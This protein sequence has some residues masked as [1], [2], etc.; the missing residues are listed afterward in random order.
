M[1]STVRAGKLYQHRDLLV[2]NKFYSAW[3]GVCCEKAFFPNF[4]VMSNNLSHNTVVPIAHGR[5]EYALGFVESSIDN[6]LFNRNI[7]EKLSCILQDPCCQLITRIEAS[8]DGVCSITDGIR[9]ERVTILVTASQ[10]VFDEH[11]ELME[12][13]KLT[14]KVDEITGLQRKERFIKTHGHRYARY[15]FPNFYS[16]SERA[17]MI[18]TR[19]QNL[20]ACDPQYASFIK[21]IAA[22][23][24]SIHATSLDHE[25]LIDALLRIGLL[26]CAVP[27]HENH[28]TKKIFSHTLH[29]LPIR[30]D[31]SLLESYF[32]SQVTF[33]FA[34]MD[35]FTLWL[36]V[37]AIVGA[38]VWGLRESNQTVDTDTSSTFYSLFMVIWGFFFIAFWRRRANELACDWDTLDVEHSDEPNPRYHG[39]TRISRITG[40]NELFYNPLNRWVFHYPISVV[41]T[42]IM[43]I[44]AFS[45]MALSLNLQG[46]VSE[47]SI[48]Y[49]ATLSSCS[50][51]GGIFDA[52][53]PVLSL[54]PVVLHAGVI[55]L[56]NLQYRHVA[57]W[58]TEQ[59]NH[60]LLHQRESSL[61]YKRFLFE[62]FDCYIALF[63]VAFYELDILKLRGELMSLYCVDS[64]RRVAT[65]SLLPYVLHHLQLWQQHWQ[66]AHS[67]KNDGDGQGGTYNALTGVRMCYIFCRVLHFVY[68]FKYTLFSLKICLCS[69]KHRWCKLQGK[70]EIEIES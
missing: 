28:L 32:G 43:L 3:R 9:V 58:L 14:N 34:W 37:P 64:A 13:L 7:A 49:V 12:F 2:G 68:S 17:L 19:C 61:V 48:I 16:P 30:K 45:V 18:R 63:Y 60:R 33:Y 57:V 50:K 26:E 35:F 69:V 15:G 24:P 11:A 46:Y 25:S 36:S 66:T 29:L 51:P 70:L 8:A 38:A 1:H 4:L 39:K 41:V 5:Y 55:M 47:G 21:C 23:Y 44:V 67:K 40:K 56:L 54:I 59:E 22:A 42:L 62:A 27:L 31:I 52:N 53:H 10:C 20:R 65:E 6:R